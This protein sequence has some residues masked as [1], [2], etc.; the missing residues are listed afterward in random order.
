MTDR[1]PAF[2]KLSDLA[3]VQALVRGEEGAWEAF[4]DRVG[5]LVYSLSA[6]VFSGREVE[7]EF[8]GVL[9]LLRADNFAILRPFDGRSELPTYLTQKICDLLA[10][11]ILDLFENDTNRAW[12]AFE[13][14]FKKDI[15]R[16]IAK[17]FGDRATHEDIYQDICYR[18]VDQDYRRIKS[19]EGHGSFNGYIRRTIRN[20]S[21]DLLRKTAGRPRLPKQIQQLPSLEQA[22]FKLVYWQG[23]EEGDLS[24]GL[25]EE[26]GQTYLPG[27]VEEAMARVEGLVSSGKVRVGRQ[28]RDRPKIV[29]LTL[30]DEEGA[31]RE[32]EIPDPDPS[33]E[34][35][36]MEKEEQIAAEE[37]FTA[38]QEAV[39]ELPVDEK[40]YVQLRFHYDKQPREIA[41]IMG[42]SE[43]EVY[44]LRQRAISKLKANLKARGIEE[45][46]W[47]SV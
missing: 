20:L 18:L 28:G 15:E 23:C 47:L 21:I 22:I 6:L 43:E 7:D 26:T 24:Q 14:F 27:Q 5:D 30:S 34:A 9:D 37:L 19:Y 11:R 12:A 10:G 36:L 40:L 17:R 16:T 35:A 3:L 32:S 41:H 2:E 44:K 31:V 25:L 33:P 8:L 38:L 1:Q 29:S 42:A 13:R 39:E 46:Q 4:V 45:F